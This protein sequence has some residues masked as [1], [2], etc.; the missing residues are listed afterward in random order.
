MKVHCVRWLQELGDITVK[1]WYVWGANVDV[2]VWSGPGVDERQPTC[3][4]CK[5]KITCVVSPECK[6]VFE[7]A[8]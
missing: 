8:V 1:R 5:H 7:R 3:S 6:R 4:E 2:Y